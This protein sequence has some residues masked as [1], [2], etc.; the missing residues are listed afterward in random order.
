MTFL[1]NNSDSRIHIHPKYERIRQDIYGLTEWVI[2]AK[3]KEKDDWEELTGIF[4]ES[5]D[6]RYN[7]CSKIQSYTFDDV[8]LHLETHIRLHITR[9]LLLSVGERTCRK[10]ETEKWRIIYH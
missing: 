5:Y 8:I 4:K 2:L 7:R 1:T 3:R 9:P 6:G 10:Q